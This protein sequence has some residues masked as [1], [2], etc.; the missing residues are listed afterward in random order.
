MAVSMKKTACIVWKFVYFLQLMEIVLQYNDLFWGEHFIS[1]RQNVL[2][3]F[4]Y[5]KSSS[6]LRSRFMILKL[7]GQLLKRTFKVLDS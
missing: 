3:S 2:V 4:L 1:F 6:Y 7:H 5:M